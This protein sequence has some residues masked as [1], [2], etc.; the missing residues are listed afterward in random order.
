MNEVNK[1]PFKNGE[2][3]P[4]RSELMNQGINTRR[5]APIEVYGEWGF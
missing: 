3:K 4:E 1:L 5:A 2:V